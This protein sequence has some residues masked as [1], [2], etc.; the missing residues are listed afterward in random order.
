MAGVQWIIKIFTARQLQEKC[1]E[2]NLDL[3]TTFNTVNPNGLWKMMSKFGC[4]DKFVEM[5]KQFHDGVRASVQDDGEHSASF[6]MTIGV[7]QGFVLAPTLFSMVF[8]AMLNDAYREG[9]VGVD[10]HF[11][12][13]GKLFS[14]RRLQAKSKV[15]KDITQDILFADDCALNAAN[16]SGM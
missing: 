2:Q 14:L 1:R 12:T 5:I 11:W 9:K 16:Q 6:P 13:D 10:F 15:T 3:Y 4:P 7:K 8:A